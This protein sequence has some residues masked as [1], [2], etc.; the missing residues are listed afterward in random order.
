MLI[1]CVLFTTFKSI[2][3]KNNQIDHT[4]LIQLRQLTG[5]SCNK[6]IFFDKSCY[7]TR[8]FPSTNVLLTPCNLNFAILRKWKH[9]KSQKSKVI[10]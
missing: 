7:P 8:L 4:H 9:N 10:I 6:S 5:F 1:R 2:L 3:R